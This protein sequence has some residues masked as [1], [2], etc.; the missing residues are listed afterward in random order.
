MTLHYHEKKL[1][2]IHSASSAL[3][4]AMFVTKKKMWDRIKT[5]LGILTHL[6]DFQVCK[7]HL[8]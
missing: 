4:S 1:F 7:I 6:V 5:C 8:G 3:F 2:K